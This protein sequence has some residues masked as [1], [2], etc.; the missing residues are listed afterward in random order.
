MGTQLH[1]KTEVVGGVLEEECSLLMTTFF[2][3]RR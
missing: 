1:P 2:K 3:S